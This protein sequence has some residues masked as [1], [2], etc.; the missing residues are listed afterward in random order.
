MVTMELPFM[1][2]YLT[3]HLIVAMKRDLTLSDLSELKKIQNMF[4]EGQNTCLY[5]P[6]IPEFLLG[7]SDTTTMETST[8]FASIWSN[9]PVIP[10]VRPGHECCEE[11]SCDIDNCSTTGSCCIEAVEELWPI[12]ETDVVMSCVYPQLRPYNYIELIYPNVDT[13]V[14][15]YTECPRFN[16]VDLET[17]NK[18]E[19]SDNYQDIETKIP[20]TDNTTMIIYKNRFCALCHNVSVTTLHYW[21][22]TLECLRRILKPRNIGSVITTVLETESCNLKYFRPQSLGITGPFYQC[23][24]VIS[25]CNVTGHWQTYNSVLEAACLAYS[26]IYNFKYRNVFCY[27]CNTK[28]TIGV[29]YCSR[30]PRPHVFVDF[31]A[32][33][34]F[35][36]ELSPTTP[37]LE[38]QLTCSQNQLYDPLKNLCRD[39]ECLFPR[40]VENGKCI[41]LVDSLAGIEFGLY[42]RMTPLQESEGDTF[43]VLRTI[44]KEIKEKINSL[45]NKTIEHKCMFSFKVYTKIN[46][47]NEGYPLNNSTQF[48]VQYFVLYV[49]MSCGRLST[50][51]PDTVDKLLSFDNTSLTTQSPFYNGTVNRYHVQVDQYKSKAGSVTRDRFYKYVDDLNEIFVEDIPPKYKRYPLIVLSVPYMCPS[52]QINSTE[53][54]IVGYT[55][56]I[57]IEEYN[58]TVDL[59]EINIET[60]SGGESFSI[61]MCTSLFDRIVQP[62]NAMKKSTLKPLQTTCG[63]ETFSAKTILTLVC[64]TIS[65]FCSIVTLLVYLKFK[66][67]KTQPG[68]N[69]IVL[70][71]ALITAQSLYQFGSG[72]SC[73]VSKL[74]CQVIGAFVHFSWLFLMFWMN[75]C[76]IHMFRVF[77]LSQTKIAVFNVQ[78]TTMVYVSICI[79]CSLFIV[80]TNVI[81]SQI[82]S[83][84]LDIGYGG[85][86]C[87]I[88]QGHMVAFLFALPVAVIILLNI[89]LFTIVIL[90]MRKTSKVQN[91]TNRQQFL[92]IYA[93]LSTLTGCTWVFG[94]CNYFLN[95][96]AFDYI[97]II[98]NASQGV[99]LFIAFVAN[100]RTLKSILTGKDHEQTVN[101]SAMSNIRGNTD[102]SSLQ[103]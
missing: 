60:N 14:L 101:K 46:F 72:Q 78:K 77:R 3:I 100:R 18:C 79:A 25:Q 68:V 41:N 93:K 84:G 29:N 67:F 33:L 54:K 36:P 19:Q 103:N 38:S 83:D 49:E 16:T 51:K 5:H 58:T 57:A 20:V 40:T 12:K 71:L 1:Y 92:H 80:G 8:D 22:V 45:I 74:S 88:S 31:V 28:D 30:T 21:E 23:Q 42:L 56:Y 69:N 85:T 62:F 27:L 52:V 32:L 81:V 63:E 13:L 34:K 44:A 97:F 73:N 66:K 70:C 50:I 98:L 24:D 35:Q 47:V 59:K 37:G 26:T 11:C 17:V 64:T 48:D 2:F 43:T 39:I 87:Y 10:P 95:I 53:L 82:S 94:F 91:D 76:C 15:M 99:F 9:L 4:C 7:Q 65:I 90:Q 102:S 61:R 96:A 6:A 55:E 89:I 75:S 86:L